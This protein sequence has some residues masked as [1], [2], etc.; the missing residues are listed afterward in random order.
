M[1]MMT[2]HVLFSSHMI[3]LVLLFISAVVPHLALASEA[4]PLVVKIYSQSYLHWPLL[5]LF[6][7]SFP[8]L[9]E[10]FCRLALS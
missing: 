6:L 9:R 8:I 3:N 10:L 4:R 7:V 1:Y 2:W 5:P